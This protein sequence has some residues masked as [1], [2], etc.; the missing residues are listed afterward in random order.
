MIRAAR[1]L[2]QIAGARAGERQGFTGKSRDVLRHRPG[3][4][5]PR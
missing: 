2:N 3:A 1:A 5:Q 4:A